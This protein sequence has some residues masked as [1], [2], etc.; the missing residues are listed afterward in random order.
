MSP[1]P[2]SLSAPI[3]SSTT[4]ESVRRG[5]LEGNSGRK[6][7]FYQAGDHVDGGFLRGQHQ[8]DAD[9]AALLRQADDV[10]LDFLG[11]GHHQIGQLVGHYDDVWHVQGDLA[12]FLVVLGLDTFHE[13]LFAQLVVDADVADSGAGEEVVSLF[14]FIDRPGQDG[15]GLAHVG[16]D[17]VHEVRQGFIWAEFDHFGV[18]QEHAN[19]IGPAGHE[20]G[21]D[22]RV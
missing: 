11:G 21:N 2:S 3:S 10:A 22:D 7:G 9:R 17:R 6:I 13:F 12:A 15:L 8:V 16:N 1:L 14:H 5:D 20:H 18:D 19:F 4:R